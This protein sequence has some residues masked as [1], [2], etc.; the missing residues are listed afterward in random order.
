MRL[1]VLYRLVWA[2]V[3]L[4]GAA[5]IRSEGAK[6]SRIPQE[7]PAG[8]SQQAEGELQTGIRLTRQG[9][10]AE[11]I[12]HFLTARGHVHD[13]Y[14]ASFN[15]ALCY[16]GTS[17]F[18]QAIQILTVLGNDRPSDANVQDLLAQAYIGAGQE[19]KGFAALQRAAGLAPKSEKLYLLV[20]DAC[21]DRRD[22]ELGLRVIGVA[23]HNLPDSA[24]LH[25]QRGYFLAM[26]DRFDDAKPEFDRAVALAPHSDVGFLASAQKSYFAGDMPQAVRAA[27]SA[28]QEGH[29]NY[30][31]LTI[32]GDALMRSGATPGTPDFAEARSALEK[33]VATRPTYVTAQI[34]F[35]ALLAM[36]NRTAEAVEH[37]EKAKQLD[38]R[39]PAVYSHLAVAYRKLGMQQQAEAMLAILAQ[40]NADQ[41]A[42]IY[43]APGERKAIP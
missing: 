24:R 28:I 17:D 15:L 31:L 23:L 29:E 35:G 10:F 25:Y 21:G 1:A 41:A 43:S 9:G 12:P 14:A 42:K 20:A 3:L 34:A 4:L 36:D 37:F 38:P 16:V 27:H 18:A 19:E 33:A 7:T 6:P 30:L 40:I 22:Y 11:A 26:L 8:G 39:N 5:N 2:G 13:E 32:L